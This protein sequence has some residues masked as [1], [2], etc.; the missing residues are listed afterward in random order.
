MSVV[1]WLLPEWPAFSRNP[2]LLLLGQAQKVDVVVTATSDDVA[3]GLAVKAGDPV[4][5]SET[6]SAPPLFFDS[7]ARVN[8][9]DVLSP[10]EGQGRFNVECYLM[11][12]LGLPEKNFNAAQI[13]TCRWLFDG[14]FPTVM[15]VGLSYLPVGR[16]GR[17]QEEWL[18][19]R[20]RQQEL[21]DRFFVKMKTKI[22]SDW[23]EDKRELESRY[24]TPD[25]L[26]HLKLFPNSSW[27]FTKW[28]TDDSLGFAACWAVAF[29]ILGLLWAVIR[30][31]A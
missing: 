23:D 12:L 9:V 15:L 7:I 3:A 28:T 17:T 8:A 30:I 29:A 31:G 25:S 19:T 10:L 14:L 24:S 16:L 1:P 5:E 4:H 11:S 2:G 22:N 13:Y 21:D 6:V 27:E 26:N 18:E 20:S